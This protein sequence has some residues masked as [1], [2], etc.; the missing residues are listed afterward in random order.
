MRRARGGAPRSRGLRRG[1]G[2]LVR[3]LKGTLRLGHVFLVFG[4]KQ[5]SRNSP[6]VH[7]N[8]NTPRPTTQM[9]TNCILRLNIPQHP[10]TPMIINHQ[11]PPSLRH[12][13]LRCE[14][15]HR[16]IRSICF[17]SPYQNIFFLSNREL[18]SAAWNKDAGCARGGNGLEVHLLFVIYVLVVEVAIGWVELGEDGGVEGVGWL[19]AEGI[20][21][22]CYG[23]HLTFV[24]YSTF[25][26]VLRSR[27]R[28]C[29]K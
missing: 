16:D 2:L 25:D 14:N 7:S 17:S 27:F 1:R 6:I 4:R 21:L 8:H 12:I 22:G 11:R 3:A 9:R 13:S 5:K 28:A 29:I 18:R 20:F 15:P 19:W 26:C 10:P 23:S 24:L